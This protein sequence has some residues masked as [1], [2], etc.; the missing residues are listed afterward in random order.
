MFLTFSE[1]GREQVETDGQKKNKTQ[2]KIIGYPTESSF[3]GRSSSARLVAPLR[4]A[5]QP[6]RHF[7][8][9]L[10]HAPVNSRFSSM[11]ST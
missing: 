11:L 2:N 9:A 5:R 1:L 10:S 6:E 8:K 3:N 7:P 4:E